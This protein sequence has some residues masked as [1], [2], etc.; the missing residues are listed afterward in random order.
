MI[1]VTHS[2]LVPQLTIYSSAGL[3]KY[4]LSITLL[5]FVVVDA[6]SSIADSFK[7]ILSSD[8]L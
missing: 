6:E 8:Y 4:N 7:I 5:L 1:R 2:N 3:V